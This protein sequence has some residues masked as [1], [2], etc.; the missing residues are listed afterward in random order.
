MSRPGAPSNLTHDHRVLFPQVITY[1]R[2]AQAAF[3]VRLVDK[4]ALRAIQEFRHWD[5]ANTIERT[6]L[7][8]QQDFVPVA[9]AAVV[10]NPVYGNVLVLNFGGFNRLLH[11]NRIE[12]EYHRGLRV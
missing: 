11:R 1:G 7:R 4:E 2:A 8:Q 12:S 5:G 10:D 6:F 9:A 3:D